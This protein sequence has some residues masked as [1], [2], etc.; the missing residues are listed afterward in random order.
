ML[1]DQSVQ[2]RSGADLLSPSAAAPES[3]GKALD[4]CDKLIE[5]LLH[6]T[7]PATVPVHE[8]QRSVHEEIS[9]YISSLGGVEAAISGVALCLLVALAG[10]EAT[11]SLLASI[12]SG[13]ATAHLTDDS[14]P[15]QRWR[16]RPT[17][18]GLAPWQERRAKE[19]LAGKLGYDARSY[20]RQASECRLSS[21]HFSRAFK[22]T[23]GCTAHQ[24]L[25]MHRVDQ[26]KHLMTTTNCPL[27]E[28]ALAVGF[29]DQ[30]HFTRIFSR[31]AN[32][33]PAAWRRTQEP[34][35]GQHLDR[36][37]S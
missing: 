22:Q 17:K 26:A 28:I 34:A 18:G 32:M 14:E 4:S 27:S 31:H 20:R 29:S 2:L 15:S 5:R 12:R 35:V 7:A 33:S 11:V 19:I 3:A 16:P 37:E 30:P 6:I 25:L 13:R 21:G 1:V 36:S 8:G 23:V 9:Q 24:W 10:P